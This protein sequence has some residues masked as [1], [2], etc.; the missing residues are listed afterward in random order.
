MS[1]RADGDVILIEGYCRVE[2]A[3]G[4]TALLQGFEKRTVDLSAC[5][6]LHAAAVQ[7]ILAFRCDIVGKPTD[8]FLSN[9]LKPALERKAKL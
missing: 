4:L 2:D 5:E 9:L 6:G 1:V 3:E 7:A 8:L